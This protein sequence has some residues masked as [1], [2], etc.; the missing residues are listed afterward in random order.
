M[1]DELAGPPSRVLASVVPIPGTSN[2]REVGG[3]PVADGRVIRS[4]VLYRGEALAKP[5]PGVKR[6]A[7]WDARHLGAYRA[8]GL[9]TVIDLRGDGEVE[10]AP[11]AW[12]EAA[13]GELLRIP[14]EEGGEGDATDYVKDLRAGTLR[15]FSSEDLAE[16][17]AR[18]A[19]SSAEAFGAAMTAM[20]VPGALPVLVHCSAGKDRTGILFALLLELLGAPR[21]LVVADYALTGHLRPNR[22]EAYGDILAEHGIEHEAVSALFETPPATMRMMLEGIVAEYGSVEVFLTS[23]AGV[24]PE[25]IDRLRDSL[26]ERSGAEATTGAGHRA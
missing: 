4:R 9:A 16:Y 25:A 6:V 8:L 15:V 12:A 10:L 24:S 2:V 3:Y 22:V 19:R 5:G 7:I 11:S 14:I 18:T 20:A 17:Y 26:T 1:D 13:G 21:E 23:R